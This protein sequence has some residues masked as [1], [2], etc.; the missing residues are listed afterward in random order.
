MGVGV[1]CAACGA[2]HHARPAAGALGRGGGTFRVPGPVPNS[3]VQAPQQKSRLHRPQR[4]T[5]IAVRI[6]PYPND[7]RVGAFWGPHHVHTPIGLP[8]QRPCACSPVRNREFHKLLPLA[9]I[10]KAIVVTDAGTTLAGLAMALTYEHAPGWHRT[11]VA[12]GPGTS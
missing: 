5:C 7:T 6:G 12:L 9:M 4:P 1:P 3:Q 10:N 8:W 11:R 2:N